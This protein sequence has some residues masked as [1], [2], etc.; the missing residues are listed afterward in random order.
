MHLGDYV[1]EQREDDDQHERPDHDVQDVG[2]RPVV[3]ECLDKH[4][5]IYLPS[6]LLSED[7]FP[8]VMDMKFTCNLHLSESSPEPSQI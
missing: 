2:L 1:P 7:I 8:R 3:D 5:A 4:L 6:I